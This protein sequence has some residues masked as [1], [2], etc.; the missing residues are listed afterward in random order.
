[1]EVYN[2]LGPGFLEAVYQE[3]LEIELTE[4]KIPFVSKPN[5]PI[6]Y[7][8]HRL[9]KYYIPD[10]MIYGKI[11]VEIKAED[12]LTS[13]DEAQLINQLKATCTELGLLVNFGSEQKLD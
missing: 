6:Y 4:R 9:K 13:G 7:K 11:V 2:V 5:I 3:T 8:G 12:H 1:M 10:F